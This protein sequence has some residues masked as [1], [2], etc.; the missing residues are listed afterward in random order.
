LSDAG[1]KISVLVVDDETGVR[2]FLRQALED[3]NFEVFEANSKA[4]TFNCIAERKIDLITLDLKLDDADGLHLAEE[5]RASR[6][7]PIVMITGRGEALDRVAGLEGGADDYVV[8]PFHPREVILRIRQVLKRYGVEGALHGPASVGGQTRFAF[9]DRIFDARKRE[10]RRRNG[11][12][13]DLTALEFRL[14]ELFLQHPGRIFSRD[15]IMRLLMGRDWSP[16]DRTVDGHVA[17]LRRKIEPPGDE[18]TLIKSVR[19]VGY[20][21]AAEVSEP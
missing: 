6:N 13:I 14:L 4:S 20:V 17:R 8:K 10:L 18:P 21:F 19:N 11:T 12:L 5:I 15:E 7:I 16:L 9:H 3:A 2:A 1:K